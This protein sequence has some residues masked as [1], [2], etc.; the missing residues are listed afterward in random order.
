[1]YD[2]PIDLPARPHRAVR[3]QLSPSD[4][5]TL[6]LM[7][8]L[9][10]GVASPQKW[11]DALQ[12][13]NTALGGVSAAI[14]SLHQPSNQLTIEHAG[15]L[16]PEIATGFA[17]MQELD[18]G[19]AAVP[20]LEAGQIYVDHDF[21]GHANLLR[22]P[23]YR[24]FLLP[25][26]IGHYALV[27]LGSGA[28]ELP[29]LS[30]QRE[31]RRRSF[32][33]H[34]R[35][36]MQAVQPHLRNAL[37]LRRQLQQQR[38]ESLILKRTLD[39]LNF[40]LLVCSPHGR[41]VIGNAAGKRWLH[42]P[43][44]PL[45]YGPGHIP[46]VLRRLLERACGRAADQPQ[47][48]SLMLP[49]DDVLVALPLAAHADASWHDALALVAIQGPQWRKPPPGTLL[50]ALFG[51]TPAEIRLVHHMMR[52]DEPLPTVAEQLQ[53]SLNTVR[54]QLRSVFQKTHTRRQSDLLRLIGQ[55][56]LLRPT[57]P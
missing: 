2:A 28:D 43:G 46:T 25:A 35:R 7:E 30:V 29:A 27:P 18:P 39:A 16:I 31:T 22:M 8:S 42:T 17:A 5:T 51:L 57:V 13:V 36:L 26:G 47:S 19:R 3:P 37:S 52:H 21:H 45:T 6:Q 48:G 56:A 34:E 54:T 12:H 41:V 14:V 24:D 38:A 11:Q 4:R 53:L 55:L 49:G 20:L 44:C 23:F 33:P 32:T 40:P 50:R 1:M 15:T 10:E 9:Y